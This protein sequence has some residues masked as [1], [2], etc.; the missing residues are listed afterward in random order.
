MGGTVPNRRLFRGGKARNVK[1]GPRGDDRDPFAPSLRFRGTACRLEVGASG[2][3][4]VKAALKG[5][6]GR[7]GNK[8]RGRGRGGRAR[9]ESGG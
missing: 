6:D 9:V 7:L 8:K 5:L 3:G 4:H 2:V 1:G